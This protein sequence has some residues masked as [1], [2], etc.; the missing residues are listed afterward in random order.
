MMVSPSGVR[1]ISVPWHEIITIS[2][3]DT[4]IF[5]DRG[6]GYSI[7]EYR[8]D[9]DVLDLVIVL[10]RS[11][12]DFNTSAQNVSK[13]SCVPFGLKSSDEVGEVVVGRHVESC[14]PLSVLMLEANLFWSVVEGHR[15][16]INEESQGILEKYG[17]LFK[18]MF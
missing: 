10:V 18:T 3:F 17:T 4:P 14:I 7:G 1:K 2:L 12:T 16:L 5:K 15:K 6:L 8:C 13:L 11:G 9:M